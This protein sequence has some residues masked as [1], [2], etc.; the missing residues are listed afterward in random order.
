MLDKLAVSGVGVGA[1]SACLDKLFADFFTQVVR[2][3][4]DVT[5]CGIPAIP[6]GV[7]AYYPAQETYSPGETIAVPL[8][9]RLRAS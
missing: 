9:H 1:L 8:E 7:D 5:S 4:S 2:Q 3:F 6:E